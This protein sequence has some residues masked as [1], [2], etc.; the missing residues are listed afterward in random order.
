MEKAAG[1]GLMLGLLSAAAVAAAVAG[2][3]AAPETGAAPRQWAWKAHEDM[4]RIAERWAAEDGA[5]GVR[6]WSPDGLR[7]AD[8]TDVMSADGR[9]EARDHCEANR[10]LAAIAMD[11]LVTEGDHSPCAEASRRASRVDDALL[12]AAMPLSVLVAP[13]AWLA[14][15]RRRDGA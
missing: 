12:L 14:L 13:L 15:P 10:K 8:G 9:V 7:Y 6:A 11:N 1:L 3:P 4:G 5:P 2:A